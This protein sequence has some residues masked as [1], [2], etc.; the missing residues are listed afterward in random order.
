MAISLALVTGSYLPLAPILALDLL[1]VLVIVN[2]IKPFCYPVGIML[3]TDLLVEMKEFVVPVN[4][5]EP[6]AKLKLVDTDRAKRKWSGVALFQ[7]IGSIHDALEEDTV[8]QRED[9][10]HF[11]YKAVT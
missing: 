11:V 3:E 9:V 1:S 5:I 10:D 7:M 4:N 8:L 6:K 2:P